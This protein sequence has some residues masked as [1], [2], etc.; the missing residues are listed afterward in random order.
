MLAMSFKFFL[1]F[2]ENGCLVFVCPVVYPPCGAG[3]LVFGFDSF[4]Y[5]V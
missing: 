3:V 5:C 4:S 2:F 1:L